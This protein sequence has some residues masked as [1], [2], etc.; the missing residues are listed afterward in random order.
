MK[1]LKRRRTSIL[2]YFSQILEFCFSTFGD[3]KSQ[4]KTHFNTILT[5]KKKKKKTTIWWKLAR[6]IK[7]HWN[8]PFS[9]LLLVKK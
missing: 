4:K 9:Q 3:Y 1:Q 7:K 2:L 6:N 8:L 5:P